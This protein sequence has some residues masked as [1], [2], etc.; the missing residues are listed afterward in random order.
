MQAYRCFA[1]KAGSVRKLFLVKV[2][3]RYGAGFVL[4]PATRHLVPS[5]A[6]FK[7]W[8]VR[9]TCGHTS[10]VLQSALRDQKSCGRS[11]CRTHTP[12]IIKV[13]PFI[14]RPDGTTAILIVRRNGQRLT[15]VLDTQDY[16]LVSGYRW[17]AHRGDVNSDTF[18]AASR[19]KGPMVYMHRFIL[20]TLKG[21]T[22]NHKD[23]D[24]LNNRR[25]NL[26]PLTQS[27]QI[28]YRRTYQRKVAGTRFK[29]R[30]VEPSTRLL[31]GFPT[32]VGKTPEYQSWIHTIDRCTNPKYAGWLRYGGANPPIK[33]CKRWLDFRNFLADMGK[34]P[35]GTL[36]RRYDDKGDYKPGN[37]KW[38][39]Q[40]E[41]DAERKENSI[42]EEK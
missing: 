10:V 28:T 39:S 11:G 22:P 29:V 19:S 17:Y 18:Y 21:L 8:K 15:C 38:E 42:T 30:G 26:E 24:G 41:R 40:V 7:R 13:N 34:R 3:K 14:H 36:L 16:P 4:A 1:P 33:I 20:P 32:A 12:Q 5:G 23:F 31:H 9:W 37:C 6:S 25:N 35:K 2:G 27:E